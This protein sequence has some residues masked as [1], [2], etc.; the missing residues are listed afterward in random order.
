MLPIKDSR[1]VG[2]LL[3][4][5]SGLLL[6]ICAFLP[7]VRGCQD[8]PV[9]PYLEVTKSI[10]ST[11]LAIPYVFALLSLFAA[12]WFLRGPQRAPAVGE[13]IF[14]GVTMLASLSLVLMFIG[15]IKDPNTTSRAFGLITVG[16]YL[17]LIYKQV[18]GFKLRDA[19]A[20]VG[21][22]IATGSAVAAIWFLSWIVTAK[23]MYGMWLSLLSALLL[24][25][26]GVLIEKDPDAP[27]K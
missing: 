4:L 24:A 15:M 12:W 5:P 6:F 19:A 16:P 23:A 3:S 18:Q 17:W 25:T 22:S 20:Q 8:V 2:R 9:Y 10:G 21:R 7:A 1:R 26:S 14:H 27:Q 13:K 11:P